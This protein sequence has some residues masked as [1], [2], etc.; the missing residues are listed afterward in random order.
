[1]SRAFVKDDSDGPEPVFGRPVTDG[2]NYVTPRGLERLKQSLAAAEKTNDE[3]EVRYYRDR[4]DTAIVVEPSAN[5][6]GVIEFGA[7]V[8]AHD[9]GGKRLQVRIVGEDEADP[10]RGSISFDSPIAQAFVGHR[11]GDRVLVQRPVGPIEYTID[12]VTYM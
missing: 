8:A 3:R 5:D 10:A 2:P 4:V 9:R 7:E 12:E 11:A 6:K 1:M